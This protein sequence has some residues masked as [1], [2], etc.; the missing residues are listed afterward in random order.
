[1]TYEKEQDALEER[2][3]WTSL[4][5]AKALLQSRMETTATSW[6]D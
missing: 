3:F 4:L 2:T 1:M 5:A 6:K